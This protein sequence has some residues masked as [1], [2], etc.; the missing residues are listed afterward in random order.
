MTITLV[1]LLLIAAIALLLL[2]ILVIPGV[3]ITGILGTLL[4]IAALVIAYQIDSTVGHLTLVGAALSSSVL[5]IL[6]FRSKTWERLSQKAEIKAKVEY[7][8]EGLQIGDTGTTVTRLNPIGTV[9]FDEETYEARSKAEFIG[10]NT[11]VEIINIDG[12]KITVQ[13]I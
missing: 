9:R 1:I 2:E 6:A 7:H 8:T 3:G 10:E 4:M 13:P 12:H 5:L 11:R